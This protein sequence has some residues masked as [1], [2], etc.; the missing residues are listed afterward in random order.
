V[1]PIALN[2]V[3]PPHPRPL[4]WGVAASYGLFFLGLLFMLLAPSL[5]LVLVSTVVR[6][7]GEL[8]AG[9]RWR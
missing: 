2:A 7:M 8:A 5:W 6:S 9:C 4:R 1:G 3:I